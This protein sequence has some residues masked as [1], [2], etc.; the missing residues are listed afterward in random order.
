MQAARTAEGHA[1]A[2]AAVRGILERT[3]AAI[4]ANAGTCGL[5]LGAED[6]LRLKTE[7]RRAIF[8]SIE[9][10]YPLGL[11]VGAL[12]EFFDLGVRMIGF[13][14]ML[15]NDV[16][17]SSTDPLGAEWGGLSPLGR[18]SSRSA[19]VWNHGRRLARFGRGVGAND[20]AVAGAGNLVSHGL[21]GGV[22]PPA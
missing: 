5:A 20:R 8:L 4:V 11:E 14:H 22:R 13:T 21:P 3:R 7:G 16:A 19:T 15:N 9:N 12:Q 18:R 2:K 6:A 10:A 1:V 17:D